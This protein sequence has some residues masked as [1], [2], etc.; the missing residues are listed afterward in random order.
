M[1]RLAQI[2]RDAGLT[3][4]QLATL[5]G[6]SPTT[7]SYLEQGYRPRRS[8]WAIPAIADA[9]GVDPETLTAQEVRA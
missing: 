5:A 9:L 1:T 7:V 3:Q 4:I 2:R 8:F 6:V